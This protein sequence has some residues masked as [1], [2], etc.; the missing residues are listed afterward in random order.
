MPSAQQAKRRSARRTMSA[1]ER[2]REITYAAADLFDKKGYASATMEDL[3]AAVGIAKPTLY[4]YF[5]S[6]DE[7]F[8][9]IHFELMDILTSRLANR[10]DRG[11]PVEEL[12]VEAMSDML[13]LIGTHRGH[14]RVFIEHYRELEPG[15]QGILRSK[16]ENYA[17]AITDLMSNAVDAGVFR[18]INADLVTLAL[19]GMSNWAY[20]WFDPGGPLSSREIARIFWDF[21]Y[22]GIANTTQ[23][24]AAG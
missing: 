7:I 13:E 21:L 11:M 22:H 2:R 8:F 5:D 14:V 1:S 15:A 6:K 3:A 20:T 16:R 4:H 19:F 18:K 23:A 17:T 10:V 12:M 24:P 9:E